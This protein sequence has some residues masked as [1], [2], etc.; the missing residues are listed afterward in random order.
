[1]KIGDII[2]FKINYSKRGYSGMGKIISMSEG[3][4]LLD[5]GVKVSI[6][7]IIK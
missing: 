4:A 7:C 6:K 2:E 3:Y 5:I 1:M